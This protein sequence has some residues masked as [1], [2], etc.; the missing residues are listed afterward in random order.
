MTMNSTI[1]NSMSERT[2]P[3]PHRLERTILIQASPETVFRFFTDSA[4]WASWW[5]PGSTIDSRPGGHLLIRYPGGIEA[6]GEVVEI[7]PPHRLV[8][9]YD[10]AS[11]AP[12]PPGASRVAIHLEAMDS[13]TR[14]RLTHEFAEAGVRDHHVQG[15]RYQLSLFANVV[16]DEAHADAANLVDAWFAVWSEP[17]EAAR[18]STLGRV[19]SATLRFRDRFGAIDGLTDLLPH[20]GAAQRFMPGIRMHRVGEIRHCQGTVLADWVAQTSE[21]LERARGT[22]VFTLSAAGR[23]E[24]VVGFWT[25]SAPR[26]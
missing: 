26:A 23:I 11:G 13:G 7:L 22:N 25:M 24:S 16:A 5:G 18:E 1:A 20:I 12:I 19:A 15:W 10:F 3:L 2:A 21:G 17:D 9:T 4:R 8:F 14:L 6:I